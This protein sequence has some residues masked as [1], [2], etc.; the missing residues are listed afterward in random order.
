MIK[1]INFNFPKDRLEKLGVSAIYLFGSQSSGNAGFLSDFDFGIIL[2]DASVLSDYKKKKD[3]YNELYDIFSDQI[4]RIVNIDI[5]FLQGANLQYQ[6]NAAVKGELMYCDDLKAA[7]DFKE[8]AMEY[9]A[10][11]APLRRLFQRSTLERIENIYE[12]SAS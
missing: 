12:K 8:K 11:F 2:K 4:K 10:D 9:Y 7:A 1:K 5:L 6:Y 3:I